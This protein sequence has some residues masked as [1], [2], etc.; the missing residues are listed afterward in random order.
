MG[1]TSPC[2]ESPTL[3][4][5]KRCLSECDFD[6]SRPKRPRGVED[7]RLQPVLDP[8]LTPTGP[9]W[10]DL[11]KAFQIPNPVSTSPPDPASLYLDFFSPSSCLAPSKLCEFFVVP[12]DRACADNNYKVSYADVATP[13]GAPTA[14]F[15]TPRFDLLQSS[16]PSFNS[17][18]SE[19]LNF[20]PELSPFQPSTSLASSLAGTPPLI[21]DATL[22]PHSL[23][24]SGLP[25]PDSFC[26]ILPHLSEKSAQF[27]IVLETIIRGQEFL[28]LPGD[29]GIP[30]TDI[31]LTIC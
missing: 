6:C 11:S 30:S 27:P 20:E 21:D 17:D 13:A 1:V 3:R 16:L 10:P 9:A 2:T 12:S 28:L 5:R 25:S 24:D 23:P 4:P 19:F 14:L 8:F 18:W 22:S 15:E 31:L 7:G 26:N 29:T